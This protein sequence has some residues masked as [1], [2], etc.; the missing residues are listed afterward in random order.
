MKKDQP[1]IK[2]IAKDPAGLTDDPIKD[3]LLESLNGQKDQLKRVLIIP[4]DISRLHSGAGLIT[5]FYYNMLHDHCQVDIMPAVGTHD[6]MTQEECLRF[7]GPD[8]P[9]DALIYHRWRSDV[10]KLGE[11]P[12]DFVRSVSEGLMNEPI[13]VEVNRRLLDPSYDLI[14]SVGQIV[15]HEVVGMANYSKNIF[16]GC[17]GSRMINGSHLLGAMYG[18]DRIMGR[19]FSPVRKVYDYAEEKFIQ[20]LP[21]RYILTVTTAD[22]AGKVS[23]HGLFAGRDRSLFEAAVALSQEKNL[24]FLDEPLQKTVVYLD[25]TEFKS[26]WLGNKAIYRTR[27]AMAKGGELIILAP[28]VHKFGEDKTIDQLIRKY[29]YVGRKTVIDLLGK[30]KDLQENQSVAAHLIHGSSD[31]LFSITYAVSKLSREEVESVNFHYQSLDEALHR[32]NP[33][34]L[35]DGMNTLPDGEKIFFIH[36]PALGLWADRSR[37]NLDR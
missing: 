18:L 1:Y 13:D 22:P 14:L 3:A 30:N 20:D 5:A 7:F 31:G 27:L 9:Y 26:T 34:Q 21:I 24:I 12:A 19:D 2:K 33:G 10:V 4:P 29:G 28:G 15:P 16:V 36:N 6:P 23:I 11:V 17:G 25:P 8:I 35:E 37:F 32:Y